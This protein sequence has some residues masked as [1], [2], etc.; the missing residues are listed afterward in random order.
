M[1]L[2]TQIKMLLFSF[3]YGFFFSFLIPIFS[4][5][6]YNDKLLIRIIFTILFVFINTIIYFGGMR[7]INDA[8]I[9]P[10]AILMLIGGYLA[11]IFVRRLIAN[12][13]KK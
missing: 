12:Y 1:I 5:W 6:L 11:E 9:H 10:Y 3:A 7:K 8:I 13:L 4:R 2:E